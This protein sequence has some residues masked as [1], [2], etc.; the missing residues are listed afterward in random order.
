MERVYAIAL[1][2]LFD[3]ISLGAI[4]GFVGMIGVWA[5]VWRG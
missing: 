4:A 1:D 3:L 5:I 2:L